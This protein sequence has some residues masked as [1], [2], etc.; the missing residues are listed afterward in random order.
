MTCLHRT[1]IRVASFSLLAFL[2]LACCL[3]C[4]NEPER[5]ACSDGAETASLSSFRFLEEDM[6]VQSGFVTGGQGSEMLTA[7]FVFEGDD[8]P[9][10]AA[11]TLTAETVEGGVVVWTES[12][13][14][15]TEERAAGGRQSKGTLFEVFEPNSPS[16]CV[17]RITATAYGQTA[18]LITESRRFTCRSSDAGPPDAGSDAGPDAG[19]ADAGMAD[20]GMADAGVADAGL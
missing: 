11:V 13:G 10:C 19:M 18:E 17:V 1:L 15:E 9:D 5:N 16:E 14:V 3:D 7:R 8:I 4:D 12:T 20:A 6:F 2:C